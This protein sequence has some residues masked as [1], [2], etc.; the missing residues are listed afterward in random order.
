M[1]K[2]VSF[3]TSKELK[4]VYNEQMERWRERE[5]SGLEELAK[6]CGVSPAYLA[7]VGRYGRIPS[8]PVLVL[9]ALNFNMPD[10]ERLLAAAGVKEPWPYDEPVALLPRSAADTG[11]LSLLR[12]FSSGGWLLLCSRWYIF[13]IPGCPIRKSSDITLVCSS[14][15][16]IAAYHVLHRLS[17]PR[18]P[19]CALICFKKIRYIFSGSPHYFHRYSWFTTLYFPICQ[20]TFR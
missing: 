2:R 15:K 20:R 16:L 10:P 18:H 1:A 11:F 13:N 19:P 8:R 17:D 6:R 7:H 4:H 14:P 5:R 12:C 3:E 9:L